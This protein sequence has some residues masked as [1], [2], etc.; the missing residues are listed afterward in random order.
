MK[1]LNKSGTYF[2]KAYIQNMTKIKDIIDSP[3]FNINTPLQQLPTP[4]PPPPYLNRESASQCEHIRVLLSNRLL[5]KD[6]NFAVLQY[7]TFYLSICL[8]NLSIYLSVYLTYLSI[9]LST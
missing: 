6:K 7:L 3:D 9:Y 4:L 8:P 1:F 2:R 5:I